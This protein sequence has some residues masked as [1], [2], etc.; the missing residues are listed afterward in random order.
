MGETI[1]SWPP[2]PSIAEERAPY[3]ARDVNRR[4]QG[5]RYSTPS[6]AF[7][8]R[9]PGFFSRSLRRPG[10]G[11]QL[12]LDCRVGGPDR[13]SL[14]EALPAISGRPCVGLN[15]TVV[16]LPHCEQTVLVSTVGR[17]PYRWP[18]PCARLALHARHRLGS[19]LKPLWRKN[20]CSPAVK[21]NSAPQSAHFGSCRGIPWSLRGPDWH[22]TQTAQCAPGITPALRKTHP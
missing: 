14:L 15:G 8:Y 10:G 7:A 19:F 6:R 18:F 21:T 4:I 16:S 9:S 2:A 13:P 12:D 22:K 3:G 11:S 1:L 17:S 20:I 5:R